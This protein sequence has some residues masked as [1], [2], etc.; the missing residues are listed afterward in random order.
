MAEAS[1]QSKSHR[2]VQW[3]D[4]PPHLEGLVALSDGSTQ[5]GRI[6]TSVYLAARA[7]VRPRRLLD[8]TVT[9][10]DTGREAGASGADV[11]TGD[12]WADADAG[13][14]RRETNRRNADSHASMANH[15]PVPN[16]WPSWHTGRRE[17]RPADRSGNAPTPSLLINS[18][19]RYSSLFGST[20]WTDRCMA[21]P[22]RPRPGRRLH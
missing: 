17:H 1:P 18:E 14:T 10:G 7:G 4:G 21:N 13:A 11:D 15:A 12:A 8:D 5:Q 3:Y 9:G 16:C 19:L 20:C 2:G 22:D 6:R